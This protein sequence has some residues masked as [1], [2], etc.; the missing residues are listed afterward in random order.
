MH[1]CLK[2]E[3]VRLIGFRQGELGGQISTQELHLI[4]TSLQRTIDGVLERL[5]LGGGDG[6]LGGSA[7]L[8]QGLLALLLGGSLSLEQGIGDLGHINAGEGHLGGGGDHVL[9]VHSAK[10]DTVEVVRTCVKNEK[11]Q[12]KVSIKLKR[13]CRQ[14]KLS[15]NRRSILISHNPSVTGAYAVR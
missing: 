11:K 13:K 10:G 3:Q 2:L 12:Q 7:G 5:S 14:N 1:Y 8:E 15:A 4:N 6:G 9:L